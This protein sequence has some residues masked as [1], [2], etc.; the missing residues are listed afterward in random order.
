MQPDMKKFKFNLYGGV[1]NNNR[2]N[3][4]LAACIGILS[5]F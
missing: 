1:I 3:I 2:T 5:I 4:V